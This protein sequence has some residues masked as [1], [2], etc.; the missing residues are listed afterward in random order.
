MVAKLFSFSIL[1]DLVIY[2]PAYLILHWFSYSFLNVLQLS[3]GMQVLL[4]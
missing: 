2:N 3:L 1:Q 4:L